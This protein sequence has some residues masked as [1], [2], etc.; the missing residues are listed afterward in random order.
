MSGYDENNDF[1]EPSFSSAART[2]TV[3]YTTYDPALSPASPSASHYPNSDVEGYGV[4]TFDGNGDD[5]QLRAGGG[6]GIDDEAQGTV[7]EEE[8]PIFSSLIQDRF[9]GF[10]TTS[11]FI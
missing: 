2:R 1:A 9:Q 4:N 11:L 6:Y 10:E 5:E 3:S 8:G 7:L